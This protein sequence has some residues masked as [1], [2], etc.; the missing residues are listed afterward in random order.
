MK[1]QESQEAF[2]PRPRL[3]QAVFLVVV[4][5]S[6]VAFLVGSILLRPVSDDYW[7]GA[8]ATAGFLGGFLDFY[9]N[10]SGG[11]I[12]IALLILL[13]GLPLAY[14]PFSIASA[15][16]FLLAA[17][18]V[19]AA[20]VSLVRSN[21]RL[22]VRRSTVLAASF[23]V[24]WL[25]HMWVGVV[26]TR[27]T[28]HQKV[29][30]FLLHWQTTNVGYIMVPAI[31][32]IIYIFWEKPTRLNLAKRLTLSFA[33]GLA[34]GLSGLTF[35]AS[36]IIFFAFIGLF[37]IRHSRN[38]GLDYFSW[39]FGSALGIVADFLS[40]GTRN[41]SNSYRDGWGAAIRELFEET[42]RGLTKWLEYSVSAPGFFVLVFGIVIG[43]LFLDTR[44]SSS[45]HRPLF[46]HAVG[47]LIFSLILSLVSTAASVFVYEASWH[48][49]T[50]RLFLFLSLVLFGIGVGS[51]LGK[52]LRSKRIDY[53]V[54][55]SLF[56]VSFIL[57]IGLTFSSV[58]EALT[59]MHNRQIVWDSGES[60]KIGGAED[61]ESPRIAS[62]W[63]I[64]EEFRSAR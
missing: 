38:R 43:L 26:L 45:W 17:V 55:Q 1:S 16:P 15:L 48:T 33:L 44:N 9:S 58:H 3:F 37:R 31:F 2:R 41:R 39:A 29:A 36:I 25:A 62:F 52:T 23:F 35:A 34:S 12:G 22:N 30:E 40:P 5:V 6:A 56:A 61:R 42:P 18:S 10:E 63:E 46:R 4:A 49:L 51:L 64:L 24:L 19:S 59:S 27:E 8:S 60:S 11:V 47:L 32:I 20:A 28:R 14:L 21:V 50:P 7:F 54:K 53:F 13:V 57:T